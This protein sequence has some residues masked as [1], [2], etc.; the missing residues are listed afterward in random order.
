MSLACWRTV[1]LPKPNMSTKPTLTDSEVPWLEEEGISTTWLFPGRDPLLPITTRRLHRVL[2]EAAHFED[3]E[4]PIDA[5]HFNWHE[6]GAAASKLQEEQH[7]SGGRPAP[8]G[9]GTSLRYDHNGL[10]Q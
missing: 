7:L 8:N 10:R 9:E 4:K 1:S 5:S 2:C 6:E 3:P